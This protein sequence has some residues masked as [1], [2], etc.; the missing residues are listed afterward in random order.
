MKGTRDESV[1]RDARCVI[2]YVEDPFSVPGKNGLEARVRRPVNS[3]F[4]T[5]AV[6]QS[7]GVRCW[8]ASSMLKIGLAFCSLCWIRTFSYSVRM[9]ST[10]LGLS[11]GLIRL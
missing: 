6:F 2:G 9:L 1:M 8:R 10:N 4:G 5:S 11:L 7:M 3:G